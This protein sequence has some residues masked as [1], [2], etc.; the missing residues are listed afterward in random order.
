MICEDRNK[1]G[2]VISIVEFATGEGASLKN[3]RVV[4]NETA[5]KERAKSLLGYGRRVRGK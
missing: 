2:P 5:E 1:L 4:A 3:E